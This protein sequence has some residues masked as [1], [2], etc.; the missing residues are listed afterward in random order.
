MRAAYARGA[1]A[2]VRRRASP[3]T[4]GAAAATPEGAAVVPSS[5]LLGG[6]VGVALSVARDALHLGRLDAVRLRKLPGPRDVQPMR[7]LGVSLPRTTYSQWN[8]GQARVG[9]RTTSRSVTWSSST[10]S[11]TSGS[12]SATGSTSHSP[13]TGDV[14]K[15]SSLDSGYYASSYVGARRVIVASGDEGDRD[16]GANPGRPPY[17]FRL[18]RT[19]WN[20]SISFGLVSIPVGLAPATASAARQSDVQFRMLHR[21]CLTPI[22]QK[23][24]CPVHDVEVELRRSRA[25][26]GDHER[27]VHPDR[28]RGARGA[29]AARHLARDRHHALRRRR[30]GRPRLLRP[31]LLPRARRH[32]G[33]AP[34]VRAAARGHARGRRRR[35]RLV[36][37]RGQGEALPDPAE[38][39]R[40]RARDALHRR[41]REE[42]GRDRRGGRSDHG[43]EGGARARPPAD[44]GPAGRVRP[45]RPAQRVP[46]AAPRAALG[47]GRGTRS[48]R[49][50]RGARDRD[51]RDR[52]HG[53][54]ACVGRCVEEEPGRREEEAAK[55]AAKKPAA[56][57]KRAAA[58]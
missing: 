8:A 2:P 35:H 56:P 25:R 44:R 16:G 40:A 58:G 36:R 14:V 15:V 46:G 18:M 47:E 32:R 37:A 55:A 27:A 43:E 26:L 11:A 1:V 29:R 20:G 24:W 3:S 33:A 31:H 28:G 41:G 6:A 19:T 53:G 9:E 52:P 48:A 12:T 17:T 22:K 38:G 42:P 57:R 45:G 39:R 50:G 4:F 10:G 49:R 54:A 34:A 51:A 21:E 7:R 5:S 30:R 23:R 13:H